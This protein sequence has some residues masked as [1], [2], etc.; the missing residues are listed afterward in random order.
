MKKNAMKA[1]ARTTTLEADMQVQTMNLVS[2][3]TVKSLRSE[4]SDH[5]LYSSEFHMMNEQN[6]SLLL[7]NLIDV[8]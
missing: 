6:L 4:K 5:M 2:F 3:N 1:C 7:W 8:I